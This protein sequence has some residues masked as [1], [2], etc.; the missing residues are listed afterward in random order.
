MFEAFR[1]KIADGGFGPQKTASRTLTGD[2]SLATKVIVSPLIKQQVHLET[3]QP[4]QSTARL[5]DFGISIEYIQDPVIAASLI[6]SLGGK[7]VGLDIETSKDS[8]FIQHKQSGLE[9]HLSFIRLVQ[10][11]GGGDK[12]FVI[13]VKRTGTLCLHGLKDINLLAHNALFEM[14]HLHHAGIDLPGIECTMLQHNALENSLESLASLSKSY[15]GITLAKEL[16]V[17]DWNAETLTQSQLEYAALDAILAFNLS[18]KLTKEI[19]ARGRDRLYPLLQRAQWPVALMEYEGLAIN[20]VQH[21]TLLNRVEASLVRNQSEIGK[22]FG[23]NFNPQSA[24]QIGKW[25]KESYSM[26]ELLKWPRTKSGKLSTD[27]HALQRLSANSAVALLLEQRKLEKIHSTFGQNLLAHCHPKT[28]RIHPNFRICGAVTGRMS[29]TQPNLQNLPR[30]AEFRGLFDTPVGRS[31]VCADYSQMETRVAAELSQDP[32]MLDIY[33]NGDDLHYHTAM[34]ITG[35]RREDITKSERQLAK[36]ANFGLLYGQGNKGFMS[37]AQNSYNIQLTGPDAKNIQAKFFLE[38]AG[39]ADWQKASI[40][41]AHRTKVADTVMGRCRSFTEINYYTGS[42]NFPVQG[43]AAE[44]LYA[45]LGRLPGHLSGLDAKIVNCVHD[46]IL[47]EASD[48]DAISAKEALER[49]M[50]EGFQ[51]I[52]PNAPISDLVDAKIGRSWADVK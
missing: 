52:F 43:A 38:Y 19:N 12:A 18:Q 28:G 40:K 25:L 1:K 23:T 26:K 41:M 48:Q 22:V 34:A 13:D 30:G 46:E 45:A 6:E 11:Y 8:V 9:P 5:Q 33:R 47:L 51:E 50:I 16:Q 7:H 2:T 42:L 44:V 17:S 10:I 31:I 29:C 27:Q 35:K 49:A 37:Y 4:I 36:A 21:A 24:D 39:L 20:S 15:L 3:S 14:K 32:K